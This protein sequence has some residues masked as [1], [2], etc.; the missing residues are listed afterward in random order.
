MV[1]E[2]CGDMIN[3]TRFCLVRPISPFSK[4]DEIRQAA[5]SEKFAHCLC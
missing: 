4:F 5:C 3:K 1:G 2:I